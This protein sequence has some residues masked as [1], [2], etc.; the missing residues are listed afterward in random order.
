MHFINILSAHNTVQKKIT[1]QLGPIEYR[2][3]KSNQIKATVDL[4]RLLYTTRTTTHYIVQLVPPTELSI[5]SPEEECFKQP[6]C[7][8]V[9]SISWPRLPIT[10]IAWCAD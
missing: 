7:S 4:V 10:F 1:Q 8:Y 2:L 5:D 9:A 3:F 6:A